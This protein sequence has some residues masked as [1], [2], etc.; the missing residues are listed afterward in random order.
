MKICLD[1]GHD[2]GYNP[3][4]CGYGY[5]EGTRMFELCVLLKAELERYQD[6]S[7]VLTRQKVEDDLSLYDR[8]ACGKGCDLLISSHSN[9]VA[10]EVNDDVDYVICYYP[11]SGALREL[12]QALSGTVA[13]VIGTR[14]APQA[15]QK[16]NSAHNADWMGVIR[17]SASFGVP[18][19]LLEHSFHT[20]T[21]VTKWLMSDDNLRLLAAAEAEVIAAAYG[22]QRKDEDR[23]AAIAAAAEG[24][25]DEN[26]AEKLKL[27]EGEIVR[28]DAEL[29]KM[30]PDDFKDVVR[31]VEEVDLFGNKTVTQKK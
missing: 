27:L 3:S 15:V 25:Y 23:R 2:K 6:V 18:A 29:E 13:R 20:N 8:A 30:S 19:L 14:Q 22:L 31:D 10:N 16:W 9:A 17:H 7:V 26:V 21:R 1:P 28:A 24:L 4:P 12:A 5:Y 11:V